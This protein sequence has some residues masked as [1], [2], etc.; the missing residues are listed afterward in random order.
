MLECFKLLRR[1][2]VSRALSF[3]QTM[4]AQVALAQRVWEYQKWDIWTILLFFQYL[5][6]CPIYI[7]KEDLPSVPFSNT[8]IPIQHQCY[9]IKQHIQLTVYIVLK[10]T[11]Y[12][13]FKIFYNFF[14]KKT[15]KSPNKTKV[16]KVQALYCW[17]SKKSDLVVLQSLIQQIKARPF[18]RRY[19]TDNFWISIIRHFGR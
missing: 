4:P 2:N 19:W 14:S 8:P 3:C 11:F 12:V 10:I 13:F 9:I 18:N 16:L 5:S 6:H 15:H 17:T 1:G 7:F